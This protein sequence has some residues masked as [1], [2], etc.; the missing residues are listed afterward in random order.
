M[1]QIKL[2]N[3]ISIL[4]HFKDIET[5]IAKLINQDSNKIKDVNSVSL[6]LEYKERYKINCP[7]F[8]FDKTEDKLVAIEKMYYEI[9]FDGDYKILK[10][11]PKNANCKSPGQIQVDLH[12]DKISFIYENRQGT[13][14]SQA[15][16][17][18]R[19]LKDLELV[20]KFIECSI[21]SLSKSIDTWNINIVDKLNKK[22]ISIKEQLEKK[23]KF[24]KQ[25]S[26]GLNP[27]KNSK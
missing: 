18:E 12:T 8:D 22:I 7:V 5:E 10:C 19:L 20:Q 27:F 11:R 1:E 13:I 17:R 15:A 24:R 26:E 3:Q 9:P 6:A 23:E 21:E 14:H 25:I 16:P 2:F 4:E